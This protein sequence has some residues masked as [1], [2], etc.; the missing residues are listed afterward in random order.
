TFDGY[1]PK[2]H[3]IHNPE[4]VIAWFR[5]AGLINIRTL[6][7]DTSVRGQRPD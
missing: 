3:G 4:E 6:P 2:Y 5:D 7:F 1:S